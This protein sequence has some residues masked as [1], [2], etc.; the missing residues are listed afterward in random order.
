MGF[1]QLYIHRAYTL[2]PIPSLCNDGLPLSDQII[3]FQTCVTYCVFQE[4][5]FSTESFLYKFFNV[6]DGSLLCSQILDLL[7]HIPLMSSHCEYSFVAFL[8]LGLLC[9]YW[10]FIAVD[11]RSYSTALM[12]PLKRDVLH[13]FFTSW[14]C[15]LKSYWVKMPQG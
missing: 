6:W 12:Q 1:H 11:C 9:I 10:V 4:G 5:F 2:P 3:H 8:K 13:F 14:W 7:S 15:S